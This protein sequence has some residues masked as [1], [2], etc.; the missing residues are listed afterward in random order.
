MVSETVTVPFTQNDKLTKA[1]I[2]LNLSSRIISSERSDAMHAV[3]ND[4][5]IDTGLWKVGDEHAADM[6]G[7]GD[8]AHNLL[9]KSEFD[10]YVSSQ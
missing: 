2:E 7:K 3:A 6:A 8:K 4:R 9:R 5:A 10:K 1:D